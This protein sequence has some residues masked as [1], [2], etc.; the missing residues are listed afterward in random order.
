MMLQH[1]FSKADLSTVNMGLVVAVC[2]REIVGAFVGSF[3]LYVLPL[4]CM[5]ENS[6]KSL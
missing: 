1:D 5:R 6:S 3:S 2:R 4:K